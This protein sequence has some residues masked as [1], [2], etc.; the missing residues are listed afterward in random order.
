M[1]RAT[2]GGDRDSRGCRRE[3]MYLLNVT[4]LHALIGSKTLRKVARKERE[5]PEA[6]KGLSG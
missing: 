5:R 3:F 6:E 1:S 4:H 2:R